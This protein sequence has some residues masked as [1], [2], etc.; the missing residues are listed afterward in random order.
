MRRRLPGN[1]SP[2]RPERPLLELTAAAVGGEADDPEV[3]VLEALGP[4]VLDAD[5]DY[6]G[7][8]VDS[9]D[10]VTHLEW[11]IRPLALTLPELGDRGDARGGLLVGRHP[12]GGILG[13]QL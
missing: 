12:V 3:A 4:A 11:L 13:E 9:D 5:A 10:L 7:V 6:S 1:D 2:L 8:A